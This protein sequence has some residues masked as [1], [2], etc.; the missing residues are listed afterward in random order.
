MEKEGEENAINLRKKNKQ[1]NLRRLAAS[2]LNWVELG[3]VP[4]VQ[5]QGSCGSCWAFAAIATSESYAIIKKVANITVGLSE[6]YALM[7]TPG[8]TCNG[9]YPQDAMRI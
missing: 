8:S 3:A 1:R 5:N 4:P 7:C 2:N 6:Q 9:G